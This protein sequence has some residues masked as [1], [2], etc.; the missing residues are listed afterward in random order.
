MTE[1]ASTTITYIDVVLRQVVDASISTSDH[2][3]E[4]VQPLTVEAAPFTEQASTCTA[5]DVVILPLADP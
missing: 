2:D 3:H 1:Q 5:I 4:Q